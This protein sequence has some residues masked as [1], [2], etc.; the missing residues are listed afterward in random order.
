V[1]SAKPVA[2]VNPFGQGAGLVDV[3][4]AVGQQTRAEP[5][6]I[7]LDAGEA[8]ESSMVYV[9]DGDQPVELTCPRTCATAT[10]P[11]HPTGC[12]V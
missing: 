3:A 1:S 2:G 9:N 5:A 11:P 8:T 4:R 12:S 6:A 7:T 10:A